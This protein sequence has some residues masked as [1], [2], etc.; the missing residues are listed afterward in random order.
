MRALLAA[1][2]SLFHTYHDPDDNLAM[3]MVGD[4][5]ITSLFS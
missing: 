2:R 3:Y 4:S 5:T 1:I